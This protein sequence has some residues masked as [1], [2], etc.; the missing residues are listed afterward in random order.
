MGHRAGKTLRH[1]LIKYWYWISPSWQQKKITPLEAWI[2]QKIG[3]TG[4]ELQLIKINAYQLEKLR[5]T[6]RECL[7]T[8]TIL[9]TTGYSTH[10]ILPVSPTS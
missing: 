8:D 5:Q 10:S 3:L 4:D 1:I 2:K 9:I 6:N 7:L